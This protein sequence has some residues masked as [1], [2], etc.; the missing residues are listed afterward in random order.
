MVVNTIGGDVVNSI[1]TG[2]AVSSITGAGVV[3]KIGAG[4]VPWPLQGLVSICMSDMKRS[5]P[6]FQKK[7]LLY[8][9]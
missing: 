8:F 7:A 3:M 9:E 2:T 4:V 5:P 6:S 1:V